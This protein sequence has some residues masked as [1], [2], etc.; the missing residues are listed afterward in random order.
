VARGGK[1]GDRPGGDLHR[2]G[3]HAGHR[4][5]LVLEQVGSGVS[6]WVLIRG[7]EGWGGGSCFCKGGGR[8]ERAVDLQKEREREQASKQ[9]RSSSRHPPS[10]PPLGRPPRRRRPTPPRRALEND[11]APVL[12]VA[13]NRGITRIRGT[14]YRRWGGAPRLALPRTLS[15][16][17]IAFARA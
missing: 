10:R 13:T 7:G 5:L 3:A 8:K 6:G 4:V 2:R 16:L 17:P 11:M 12:V 14:N 9:L 15:C 1:G